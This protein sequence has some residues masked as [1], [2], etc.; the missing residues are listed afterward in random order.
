MLSNALSLPP[1]KEKMVETVEVVDKKGSADKTYSLPHEKMP[2]SYF[3]IGSGTIFCETCKEYVRDDVKHVCREVMGEDVAVSATRKRKRAPP[4]KDL[5][6]VNPTAY[7]KTLDTLSKTKLEEEK[8]ANAKR[9]LSEIRDVNNP[10][11]LAVLPPRL[12]TLCHSVLISALISTAKELCK[13]ECRGCAAG[14][15]FNHTVCRDNISILLQAY[16]GYFVGKLFKRDKDGDCFIDK[17]LRMVAY[18]IVPSDEAIDEVFCFPAYVLHQYFL[19]LANPVVS[20]LLARCFLS[21][22]LDESPNDVFDVTTIMSTMPSVLCD[23]KCLT[24]VLYLE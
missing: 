20:D 17:R 14:S 11:Y 6:K 5:W 24:P 18:D 15:L 2:E 4:T 16:V 1:E 7:K 12:D 3:P 23:K 9:E 19:R 13:T 22:A 10:A 8:A 21:L